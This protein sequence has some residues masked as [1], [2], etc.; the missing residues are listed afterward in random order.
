M[1][2]FKTLLL[3][4]ATILVAASCNKEEKFSLSFRQMGYYF[5]WGGDAV[6]VTYTSTNVI[7]V[8]VKKISDNWT[9]EVNHGERTLTITPPAD[10]GT[11]Q[12]RNELRTGT[13]TLNVTS[14]KG[15]TSTYALTLYIIGD[16]EV[17]VNEGG[18]Y[19]NCY[20]VTEPITVY[21]IDVSHDGG[22]NPISGITDVKVLWQSTNN[23]IK[24]VAYNG[25][26]GTVSFFVDNAK[27]DDEQD[28]YENDKMIVPEGNAVLA[29]YNASENILWSWHIWV[30]K[31]DDNPLD[32]HTTYANG[33][34][35]MNKNLGAFANHNGESE[36]TDLIHRSYGLYYQWGRKDPFPRPYSYNCSGGNDE[37][38]YNASGSAVYITPEEM[39][40]TNG[41]V[42]YTIQH[43]TTYITNAASVGEGG[44][45]V[46]DWMSTSDSSL[47]NDA[48]KSAYDPCPYGWRVPRSGA[49]NDLTLSD[50]EDSRDLEE[51]RKRYGWALTDKNGNTYFYLG[52]GFR[53]YYNGKI[54]NMNH[55]GDALYPAPEPWEGY[56]WTSGT[57]ADGKQSTCMYFDLT[58]TRTINKFNLNYPSKRSNAMQVRCVK[59]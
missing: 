5:K 24:N 16:N 50:A 21:T 55:K 7:K 39:S 11:E 30:I 25:D 22:G 34:T 37:R 31:S 10:P 3:A 53:S 6:K 52:G 45:G 18:K 42:A 35:F 56:Y 43:P 17:M 12:E 26:N 48:E 49:F 54:V 2:I 41:N 28:I 4:L 1:K 40:A 14:E 13:L 59:E 29:A 19:A 8:E 57:S 32:D 33:V 46:G 51:A 58:T 9:C 44:D 36:D 38:I 20:V 23:P 15:N 47:W 27:D